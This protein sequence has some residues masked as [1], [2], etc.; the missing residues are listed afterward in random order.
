M[1]STPGRIGR[2][3]IRKEI[4]RGAMGAILEGPRQGDVVT[5]DRPQVLIGRAAGG[6]GANIEIPDPEVSRANAT[7]TCQGHRI[8]LR[9]LGSTNGTFVGLDRIEEREIEDH[10]EFHLG[11]TRF[12]LIVADLE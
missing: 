11:R 6:V 1:E 10:A 12:M 8:V 9:D 7:L 5:L 2:Y 3:E 4:G